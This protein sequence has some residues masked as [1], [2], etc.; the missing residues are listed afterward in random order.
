[1]CCKR[2]SSYL[3]ALA[4]VLVS[5]CATRQPEPE[6]SPEL[7]SDGITAEEAQQLA[8]RATV[9]NI[10]PRAESPDDTECR[11]EYVTGS[12]R[13]RVV[14][15]TQ[16]QRNATRAAAQDWY[17]SGGRNGEISQVPVVVP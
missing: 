3:P 7:T 5:A 15:Q 2:V 9:V 16:A 13:P 8:A 17:R 10:E 4:A 1:M 11:K 12:H 6:T 14:C